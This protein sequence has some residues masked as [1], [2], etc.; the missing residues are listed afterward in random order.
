MV[1]TRPILCVY[2]LP[3]CGTPCAAESNK[4][5]LSYLILEYSPGTLYVRTCS[6]QRS[7]GPTL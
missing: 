3:L 5:I 2:L 6:H 7:G 4:K 1:R